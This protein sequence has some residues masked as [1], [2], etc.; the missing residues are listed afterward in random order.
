MTVFPGQEKQTGRRIEMHVAERH[1][2][3]ITGV[4]RPDDFARADNRDGSR[5]A[6]AVRGVDAVPGRK[7][8][9]QNVSAPSIHRCWSSPSSSSVT[10]GPAPPGTVSLTV[11]V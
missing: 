7:M 2:E 6:A 8:A 3:L 9:M 10:A 5:H 11:R 4:V 1:I